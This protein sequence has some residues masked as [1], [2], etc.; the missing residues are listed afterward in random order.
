MDQTKQ[1]EIFKNIINIPSVNDHEA[2]VA[3]YIASLFKPY[4]DKVDV[5]HVTYAPGRDNLV[6]TTKGGDGPVFGLSGHLDTVATGNLD[7]WATDP[8]KATVKDGKLYGRGAADMKSGVAAIVCALLEMLDGT[9]P[10]PGKIK[11]LLTVGEETG[12]YGAAELTKKGYVD[13]LGA[14]VISE[15]GDNMSK[16]TYT[17]KGVI[18]Y[19]VTSVG[20]SVHSS[21]PD[22]GINAITNLLDFVNQVEDVLGQFEH[23]ENPVLGHQVSSVTK[24]GGGDQVN[25]IPSEAWM[26][27]NIRT[28]PEHPNKEIYAALEGLVAKCNQMPDHKLSIQYSYPEEPMVGDPNSKLIQQAKSVH[29]QMFDDPV[30]VVGSGG[31]NDGS[32]FT[33]SSNDFTSILIGPGSATSHQ[34]NE[35]CD[36]NIY[37]KS[38]QFYEKLA[39]LY[40]DQL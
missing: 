30:Q 14:L 21:F 33:Q 5:E 3:D 31:A 37:Y 22:K 13:D 2:D 12:E 4:S 9:T 20:K 11:L 25:S 18:D 39:K 28:I 8:F 23:V 10:L 32:E 7:D 26:M 6:V 29:D 40:F 19:K 1:L 16:L 36:L 35:Y 24:I 17:S 34:P 38:V 15:P 27:G